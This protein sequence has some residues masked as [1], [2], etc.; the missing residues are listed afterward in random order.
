MRFIGYDAGTWYIYAI[1]PII[2]SEYI[3]RYKRILA[4]AILSSGDG[5]RVAAK[6]RCR[7]MLF[8]LKYVSRQI[9]LFLL[10]SY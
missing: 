3:A 9:G 1:S 8:V 4:A 5:M 10:G 6:Y 2:G 7:R